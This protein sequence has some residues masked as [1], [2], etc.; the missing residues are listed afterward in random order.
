MNTNILDRLLELVA[1][2]DKSACEKFAKLTMLFVQ[3]QE[4]LWVEQYGALSRRREYHDND[5]IHAIALESFLETLETAKNKK[6]SWEEFSQEFTL[7]VKNRITIW[8]N[9]TNLQTLLLSKFANEPNS[10]DLLTGQMS[11]A[12]LVIEDEKE[13][14]LRNAINNVKFTRRENHAFF[15]RTYGSGTYSFAEMGKREGVASS[16]MKSAYKTALQKIIEELPS[17]VNTKLFAR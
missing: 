13:V 8:K 1:A 10:G 6:L 12:D 7:A 4:S 9:K 3:N 14:L 2:G 11:S 5:S 17:A 15:Q 16:T